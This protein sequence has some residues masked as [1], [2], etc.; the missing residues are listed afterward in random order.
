M[1]KNKCLKA[2]TLSLAIFTSWQATAEQEEC[3]EPKNHCT[4]LLIFEQATKANKQG[5]WREAATLASQ[6]MSHVSLDSLLQYKV[7]C[8]SLEDEGYV[9]DIVFVP[10]DRFSPYSPN[11]LVSQIKKDHPPIP[12]VFVSFAE[13][14]DT[15]Q[16]DTFQNKLSPNSGW[17]VSD[18]QH[19]K[20][21]ASR[22]AVGNAGETALS[23]VYLILTDEAGN[24]I[25][26]SAAHI[27]AGDQWT[28]AM[29][30][31]FTQSFTV[32]LSEKDGFGLGQH[33]AQTN[34][35]ENK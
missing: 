8:L 6:A 9:S 13:Q 2:S 28:Q 33:N 27:K 32:N 29:D 34:A 5:N 15:F 3:T 11:A 31:A 4:A 18:Y 16:N 30:V 19:P 7:L 14:N 12:Y 10:C 20:A 17:Q 1:I 35:Q 21:K 26:Q 23:G 24:K 25:S 22:F